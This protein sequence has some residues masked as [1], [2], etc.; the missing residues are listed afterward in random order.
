MAELA[1]EEEEDW[2]ICCHMM[3]LIPTITSI[4]VL[5]LAGA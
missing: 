3:L 5:Q 2:H 1:R 4:A